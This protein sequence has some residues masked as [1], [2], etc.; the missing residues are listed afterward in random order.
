[1]NFLKKSPKKNK[2]DKKDGNISSGQSEDD[3]TI[4]SSNDKSKNKP[5]PLSVPS[6]ASKSSVATHVE[7]LNNLRTKLNKKLTYK[8]TS[9]DLEDECNEWRLMKMGALYNGLEPLIEAMRKEAQDKMAIYR[10]IPASRPLSRE[11]AI[12]DIFGSSGTN[13]V[14]EPPFT[15]DY[16]CNIHVGDNFYANFDCCFLDG[17]DIVIGNDV[18]FGPSVHIYT[19]HHPLDSEV[20]A[21]G[22]ELCHSV[23]IGNNVWIGGRSIV[24]PG[25]VVGDGA[26]IGAG[27]VVTKDVPPF[28]IVAGNPARIIRSISETKD[29]NEDDISTG[30]YCERRA[31]RQITAIKDY[32]NIDASESGKIN[33]SMSNIS[34]SSSA[35]NSGNSGQ[36][37]RIIKKFKSKR[38]ITL[39]GY[40][41]PTST[42]ILGIDVNMNLIL[43]IIGIGVITTGIGI[44]TDKIK[45]SDIKTTIDDVHKRIFTSVGDVIPCIG[46][47]MK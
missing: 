40:N 8:L 39:D 12:K 27:S 25:V 34:S 6:S 38:N 46:K 29:S 13:I 15:C 21:S 5:K 32:I 33:K 30:A 19:A 20:R 7:K 4:D 47:M 3:L 23:V 11:N 43:S 36:A 17:A 35:A 14:V 45:I 28:T 26:V 10:N 44:Y 2:K 9:E 18:K 31:R 16:G 41:D 22:L 42:T 37:G 1:M 24:C